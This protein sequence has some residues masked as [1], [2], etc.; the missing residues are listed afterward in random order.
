MGEKER[1]VGPGQNQGKVG[2]PK[3]KEREREKGKF[4]EIK[5]QAHSFEFKFWR[6]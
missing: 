3:E 4:F 6:I 1:R 2:C 5:E